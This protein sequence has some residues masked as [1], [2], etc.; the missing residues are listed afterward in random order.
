[1]PDNFG[2]V[3]KVAVC[4]GELNANRFLDA[5]WRMLGYEGG[6]GMFTKYTFG[7]VEDGPPNFPKGIDNP[8]LNAL[9]ALD[10]E[11]EK[12]QKSID[13]KKK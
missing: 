9:S 5:K 11:I 1:M 12:T 3:K 2:D 10:A 4:Y 13:K 7:W 6:P 8:L